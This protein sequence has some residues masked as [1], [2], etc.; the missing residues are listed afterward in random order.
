MIQ[1]VVAERGKTLYK[2]SLIPGSYTQR[3]KKKKT[4]IMCH[5]VKKPRQTV[6][7]YFTQLKMQNGLQN[8][9]KKK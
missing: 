3:Y 4:Q 6:S 7:D 8:K 1:S 5:L 9:I 2:M